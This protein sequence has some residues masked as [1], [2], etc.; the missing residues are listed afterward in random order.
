E[1]EQDLVRDGLGVLLD[2][3]PEHADVTRERRHILDRAIVEVE[4]DSGQEPLPARN[5]GPLARRVPRQQGFALEDGCERERGFGCRGERIVL[6]GARRP[7]DEDR[8]SR[9]PALA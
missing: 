5:E 6:A 9:P 3:S 4:T 2:A 8:L 7:E 1:T